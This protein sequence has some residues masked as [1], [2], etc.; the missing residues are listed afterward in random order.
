MCVVPV[1]E[2]IAPALVAMDTT[3]MQRT[4]A[5][6]DATVRLFASR[7]WLDMAAREADSPSGETHC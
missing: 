4:R 5:E 1:I 3:M 7:F 2:D 6:R